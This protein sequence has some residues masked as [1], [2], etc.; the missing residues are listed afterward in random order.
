MLDLNHE[1][2][3]SIVS[4]HVVLKRTLCSYL[5]VRPNFTTMIKIRFYKGYIYR[6]VY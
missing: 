6:P 5:K 4:R 1:L 2:E 3:E